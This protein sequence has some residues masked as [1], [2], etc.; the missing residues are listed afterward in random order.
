LVDEAIAHCAQ[1]LQAADVTV[2]RSGDGQAWVE[3][4]AF[5]LR[6]AVANFIE[7]AAAFSPAGSTIDARVVREGERVSVVV[8]DRGAGIPDYALP[9]VFE[10]FYSLPRPDGGSRS[11]GLGLCFV[12]E[13]AALHAGTATLGNREGGG[14][15]ATLDLPAA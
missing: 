10:R 4:D 15:E 11:S 12:A 1:R 8:A 7:N 2:Q 14:A 3:G 9:R 6:Q 5:L 13:V